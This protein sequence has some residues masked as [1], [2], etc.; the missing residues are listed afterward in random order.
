METCAS[1]FEEDFDL[2]DFGGDFAK[3]VEATAR[4]KVLEVEN[5]LNSTAK[6]D[7]KRNVDIVIGADTM[8]TLDGEM[9]GKPKNAEDALN[10]LRK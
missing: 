9:Y 3:F 8:V 4:Q 6:A 7:G 1:T 2:N 5:R 10:T